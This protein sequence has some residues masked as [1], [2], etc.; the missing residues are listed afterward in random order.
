[1]QQLSKKSPKNLPFL[2]QTF[3]TYY[4][5][6]LLHT[7]CAGQAD[8]PSMEIPTF[9]SQIQAA[10]TAKIFSNFYTHSAKLEFKNCCGYKTQN[11]VCWTFTVKQE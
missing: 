2:S 11:Q 9:Q 7:P 4:E 10:Y 3:G 8:L 1:M 5:T 6:G